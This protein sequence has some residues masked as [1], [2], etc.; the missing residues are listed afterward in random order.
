MD[1]PNQYPSGFILQIILV[2]PFFLEKNRR[3]FSLLRFLTQHLHYY[4]VSAILLM[5]QGNKKTFIDQ[6]LPICIS[7]EFIYSL[8]EQD[9]TQ[10][11]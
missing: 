4:I 5:S 11:K 3:D 8:P 7:D 10:L 9:Y 1:D 6:F 2:L